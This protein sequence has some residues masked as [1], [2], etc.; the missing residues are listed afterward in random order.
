MLLDFGKGVFGCFIIPQLLHL[1]FELSQLCADAAHPPLELLSRQLVRTFSLVFAVVLRL[2]DE[3]INE[4]IDSLLQVGQF[5]GRRLVGTAIIVFG[6]HKLI[7]AK[8]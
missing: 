5:L 7:S 8:P 2:T 4:A 1:G 3:S 6:N